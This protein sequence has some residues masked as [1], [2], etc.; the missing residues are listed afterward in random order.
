MRLFSF[1]CALGAV[2][3]VQHL[4]APTASACG[5]C[6]APVGQAAPVTAHRMAL[7]L[8]EEQTTLWDQFQYQGEPEDFVW[9]L[10]VVAPE[11][12]EVE[13]AEDVFFQALQQST[14]ITLQ[15]PTPSP[16]GGG[17]GGIGC[18]SSSDSLSSPAATDTGVTVY[19]EE[20]VGPYET[21]V[22]GSEDGGTLVSW[23]QER[24]Y[25]VP[26]AL[27]P[28]I[29]HYIDLD[30]S[31]VVLR[32]SPNAGVDRMQPVRVSCPGAGVMLPLRMIAAGVVD[33]VS[34]ELF[35]FAEGRMEAANFGNAEVDRTALTY[36]QGSASF[37]YD[38]LAEEALQLDG[39]MV[40][41][42]EAAM[43]SPNL[44]QVDIWDAD[45]RGSSR[46][47]D[48]WAKVQAIV[49][50]SY[51]TRMRAV[52]PFNAL[53]RDLLLAPSPR[54]ELSLLI[55]VDQLASADIVAGG[56]RMAYAGLPAPLTAFALVAFGVGVTAWRRRR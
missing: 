21:V 23:L 34:L 29:Q 12:V 15:G 54:G 2:F 33:E 45:L 22:L 18:A 14:Q 6:F 31:F 10:P 51:L 44:G 30:A 4:S 38:D 28:T 39:R 49:P 20:T 48:D 36:D 35:V 9:V 11:G 43:L 25:A 47:V 41:L 50:G 53:S 13:L 8:G 46:P 55:Q 17:G 37:N 42:T 32:L 56:D 3:T 16:S 40:W 19:A 26:E 27:L 24:G 5:G 1:L 7:A 52:L